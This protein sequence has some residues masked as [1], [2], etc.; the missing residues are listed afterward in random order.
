MQSLNLLLMSC[1]SAVNA[2]ATAGAH[3]EGHEEEFTKKVER[4]KT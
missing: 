4:R 2:T 3:E 1:V